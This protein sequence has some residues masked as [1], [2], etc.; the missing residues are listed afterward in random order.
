MSRDAVYA[1]ALD[2]GGRVTRPRTPRHL[3]RLPSNHHRAP[4]VAKIRCP[5]PSPERLAVRS[6][7]FEGTW[8][9]EDDRLETARVGD[10]AGHPSEAAAD[11]IRM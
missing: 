3:D 10:E 1:A 2:D 5:E 11:A 4:T 9:E 7:S 6:D 8:R